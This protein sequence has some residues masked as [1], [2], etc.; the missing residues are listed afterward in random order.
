LTTSD[1]QTLVG[2][3]VRIDLGADGTY[4][5]ELLELSGS[6]WRGR[7]RITGVLT[8]AQH[9]VQGN[10]GRRGHRPGEFV[11]VAH[12]VLASATELGHATYLEAIQAEYNR[13]LGSHSGA[14]TSLHAW[15]LAALGRALRAA[16][17]AEERRVATGAWRL[18]QAQPECLA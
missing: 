9:L 6:P 5:G 3:R 14:Q 8:P 18:V 17:I 10:L 12:A 11:D 16:H 1:I 2:R 7:A 15:A 13:R 4:V